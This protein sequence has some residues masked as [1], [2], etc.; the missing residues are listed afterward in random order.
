MSLMILISRG[1]SFPR[2][3]V[4]RRARHVPHRR[5]SARSTSARPQLRSPLAQNAHERQEVKVFNLHIF[6]QA[7]ASK[8]ER[9]FYE[10]QRARRD[11]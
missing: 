4:R 5:L 2:V 11:S 9:R 10:T 1:L 7:Y 6:N 3:V 8:R